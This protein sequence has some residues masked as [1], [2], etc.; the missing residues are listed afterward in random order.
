MAFPKQRL[1]T[2]V[3]FVFVFFFCLAVSLTWVVHMQSL[4][5]YHGARS[6]WLRYERRGANERNLTAA[7]LV[8]VSEINTQGKKFPVSIDCRASSMNC[9]PWTLDHAPGGVGASTNS[10]KNSRTASP[11]LLRW[12]NNASDDLIQES[13][14][15]KEASK[16]KI[17]QPKS[18]EQLA[19]E[20]SRNHSLY[21][22]VFV[23]GGVDPDNPKHRLHL[24]GALMAAD[25][26]Q[27]L[28]SKADVHVFIQ[29]A[30]KSNHKKINPEEAKW[31]AVLN[32]SVHYIPK[33]EEESFYKINLE[34]FRILKMTEYRRVAF[35]DADVIPLVNLD[36]LMELSDRGI[37]KDNILVSG[38]M[39][40]G[41]GGFFV[42]KPFPGAYERIQQIIAEKD[43]RIARLPPPYWDEKVGWGHVINSDDYWMDRKRSTHN[44][45]WNFFGAS[46]DQGLIYHWAKYECKSVSLVFPGGLIENW[47]PSSSSG[48]AKVVLQKSIRAEEVFKEFPQSGSICRANDCFGP[49]FDDYLHFAGPHNKPWRQPPPKGV[50]QMAE[51]PPEKQQGQFWYWTLLQLTKK[52]KI[53]LNETAWKN[54]DTPMLGGWP[55]HHQVKKSLLA[56]NL[57]VE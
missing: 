32:I 16:A 43:K 50:A 42:L 39:E 18:A 37:L 27:Q 34:K 52:L 33:Y 55:D 24:H 54:R 4:F 7:V 25:M 29:M 38:K 57:T 11:S 20:R 14:S 2:N 1:V 19:L 23:I 36:Y 51:P 30:Y 44:R 41:N 48:K 9:S 47:G 45:L 49:V 53:P 21:A 3:S 56:S 13:K 5:Q 22:Y 12:Q 6:D 17:Q 31:L 15:A 26:L 46:A 8:N 40:P 10:S 28:G 35:M